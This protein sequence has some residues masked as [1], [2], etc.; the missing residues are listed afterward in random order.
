MS[1]GHQDSKPPLFYDY[2]ESH[3]FAAPD[4]VSALPNEL[5]LYIWI[6][7][8]NLYDL[9]LF[10][11]V[12]KRWRTLTSDDQMWQ[13]IFSQ[14]FGAKAFKKLEQLQIQTNVP[15]CDWREH[16]FRRYI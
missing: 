15:L 12:C 2:M 9:F 7:L 5:L 13:R 14:S 1:M 3:Q 4:L 8:D 16:F 6:H 11:Q 10:G